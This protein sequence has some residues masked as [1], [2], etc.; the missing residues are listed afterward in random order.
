VK[1]LPQALQR[2]ADRGLAQEQPGGSA[3]DIAFLRKRREDDEQV[4]ISLTQM[5][6][7]HNR[8]CHYA[9]DLFP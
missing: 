1:H 2:A 3:R 9:L 8:Y 5:R 4:K 7:A 6:D